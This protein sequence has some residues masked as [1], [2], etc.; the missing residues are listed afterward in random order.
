MTII[1]LLKDYYDREMN[2]VFCYSA[3]WGM[4]V[5]KKGYE[6]E[7]EDARER[8]DVLRR[9]LARNGVEV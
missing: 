7:W 2:N 8:A 3:N 6:R 5:P 1:E 4:T 9:T